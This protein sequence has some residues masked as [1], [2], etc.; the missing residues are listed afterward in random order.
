MKF[1]LFFTKAH[2]STTADGIINKLFAI[3]LSTEINVKSF[4]LGLFIIL[5][6]VFTLLIVETLF[7]ASFSSYRKSGATRLTNTGYATELLSL[8][9]RRYRRGG[10]FSFLRCCLA[11]VPFENGSGSCRDLRRDEGRDDER[12]AGRGAENAGTTLFLS[13]PHHSLYFSHTYAHLHAHIHTYMIHT[14]T[15]TLS[16]PH[17]HTLTHVFVL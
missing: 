15:H 9:G 17:M 12:V 4:S 10:A 2:S 3:P 11:S 8:V 7:F 14:H 1:H 6:Y 5:R 13:P 16:H